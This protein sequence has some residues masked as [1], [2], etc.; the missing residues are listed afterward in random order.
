M[1]DK[2]EEVLDKVIQLLQSEYQAEHLHRTSSPELTLR[3][4][5]NTLATFSKNL[6]ERAWNQAY[7]APVTK[8]LHLDSD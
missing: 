3:F 2:D 5:I 6:K 1:N 7:S 8:Y 4:T